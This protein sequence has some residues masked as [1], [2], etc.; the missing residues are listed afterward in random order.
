MFFAVFFLITNLS[1]ETWKIGPEKIEVTYSKEFRTL[2]SA[3]CIKNTSCLAVEAVK[4][5]K[6]GNFSSPVGENP[7]SEVC[8]SQKGTVFVATSSD[9]GT[10]AFCRFKDKSFVSL[11]GIWK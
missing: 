11:N 7:G 8:K 6:A 4:N 10:E 9:G 1:A 2:I 3:D 5:K